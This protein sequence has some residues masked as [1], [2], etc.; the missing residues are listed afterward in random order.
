M[1][2]PLLHPALRSL[3]LACAAGRAQETPAPPPEAAPAAP[4]AAGIEAV[5]ASG[6]DVD[7]VVA[8]LAGARRALDFAPARER[9]A[10]LSSR[11][12]DEALTRRLAAEAA[13]FLAESNL[14]ERLL[15]RVNE[16]AQRG[17][18]LPWPEG[19]GLVVSGADLLGVE[20]A[21]EGVAARKP[22][23]SFPPEL[24]LEF[25]A[26]LP[27]SPAERVELARFAF[28]RGLT[29]RAEAE[30]HA[31]LESDASLKELA[32]QALAL[33][34]REEPP[35]GGYAWHRGS[36]LPALEVNRR[37]LLEDVAQ[38]LERALGEATT[39]RL[40]EV[41]AAPAHA[42]DLF[43][44][45]LEAGT[46][47]V[48]A[49]LAR[50][51]EPP[52]DWIQS[53]R[54]SVSLRRQRLLQIEQWEPAAKAAL[55][56]IGRYDKPDQPKVDEFRRQ[57][58]E[59]ALQYQ[60]LR[61]SD[62]LAFERFPARDAEALLL[63][64][65]RLEPALE[66][67]L[68]Y[69]R[70]HHG[71]AADPF[72]AVSPQG[73]KARLLPGRAGAGLEEFA[74][75]LLL[76]K[77]NRLLDFIQ[78]GEELDRVGGEM[79]PWER[80]VL[81][82][83]L[84]D[85]LD[86]YNARVLTSAD[87][88]EYQN[89]VATNE[90]RRTLLL[91]PFEIDERVVIAAR[92]HSQEMKDLGYFGHD[93][94]T[95][96]LRTPTDRVQFA[97][98][99]G[100]AGENCYAGGGGGRGAFEGWYHSPGHHRGMVGGGPHLGVGA[101]TTHALWTQNFAG[102]DWSWRRHFPTLTVDAEARIAAAIEK[103]SRTKHDTCRDEIEAL[104]ELGR[105]AL[106]AESR[107]LT[108]ARSDAAS[109]RRGFA[110]RLARALAVVAVQEGIP[111]AVDLAVETLLALLEDPAGV[112]RGE[113]NLALEHVTGRSFRFGASLEP[114]QRAAAVKR[115][116]DWWKT[117]REG[118]TPR[119]ETPAS[120][121]QPFDVASPV[122]RGSVKRQ[123]PDAPLKV[124]SPEERL[125][126]ARR[127]GGSR[128]T[129]QAVTAALDWLV[130]HQNRDGSWGGR[131]FENQCRGEKCGGAAAFDFDA[132]LTGLSLLCL[133][134]G[135]STIEIG[136][137]RDAVKK[138]LDFLV[139]RM[140]EHGKFTSTSGWYMYQHALATQALVE[141]YGTSGDPF[142]KQAAQKAVDFLVFA[143][144]REL[145]GW[146][147]EARTD[148]DTSVTGWVVL[149]LMT[150]HDAR[151]KVAGF[152]GAREWI[153]RVTEPAYYRVGYTHALDAAI[154]EPRLTAVGLVCRQA[155]GTPSNHPAITVGKEWCLR[156]LPTAQYIDLYFAYYAT[157][158]LFQIGGEPWKRWN[159][160]MVPALLERIHDPR[161]PKKGCRRGSFDSQ[162][163]FGD[164]GG[165]VY[166]T[167]LSCL[168]LEV[169]Y[170]YEK[171]PDVRS[172]SVTGS[173]A[174]LAK[175]LLDQ[176]GAGTA[177]VARAVAM[178]RIEEE[179]GTAAQAP[180]LMIV[181]EPG[182]LSRRQDAAE[183]LARVATAS[184][185]SDLLGLLDDP[186]PTIQDRL[187][188]ALARGASPASV[189]DLARRLADERGH[190]RLW[191]A[192][193][194]GR[195]GAPEA[196]APLVARSAVEP[197]ANVK[198]EIAGAVRALSNRSALDRILDDAG[199]LATDAARRADLRE[200]LR[201][202]EGHGLPEKLAAA[203]EKQPDVYAACLAPLRE[204]GRTGLV[205]LL[206]AALDLED[207][208]G[209]AL[210][211]QLLV[212]LAGRSMN[213]DA[214][215]EPKLRKEAVA[216]WGAWWKSAR[217]AF[218]AGATPQGS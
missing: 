119:I 113:A 206:I 30:L 59:R 188:Q 40:A 203:R 125:A 79:T 11:T 36:F 168:M 99:G 73:A 199:F 154:Q 184:I 166:G 130:R 25:L 115:W 91:K 117:A 172:L 15:G 155:L 18:P 112:V 52:R 164:Y 69:R 8:S 57:L 176:L 148:A 193:T 54:T 77:S 7:A 213:F 202:L 92:G 145:G 190:V 144:N 94:P 100:G 61:R 150:A 71:E 121:V 26:E 70:E 200:G 78:R 201:V 129:E 116:R 114:A 147:Y 157:L 33:H 23:R 14:F 50:L 212:A 218:Q 74:R 17:Q 183:I 209:R 85:A 1:S 108:A 182:D 72:P 46:Q 128:Q 22:W 186:D 86:L 34:R 178:R 131:A 110:T 187:F 104:L 197:D 173:I 156:Q 4:T 82:D 189:P 27:L 64:L 216:R 132:A 20:L 214:R 192:R 21:R 55:E 44:P 37:R 5:A 2:G 123:S 41:V 162:G 107:A 111:Q 124:F 97:G 158:A 185:L 88:E 49:E 58:A 175:P 141:G 194:L 205:P 217:T 126:L 149:A 98:Y 127:L 160:A 12:Q 105:D 171:F 29:A 81:R 122:A 134:H 181:R 102:T 65:E 66:A 169:Y 3:A 53:Y 35:R 153:E 103:L 19:G 180:L 146:R 140:Q 9:L 76:L 28:W 38:K 51:Y 39:L 13:D 139:S 60:R 47:R 204:L 196:L 42:L 143:Q 83:L 32:D 93:S 31:A 16:Q 75:A 6:D 10:E 109:E 179:F 48:V 136:P 87:P 210:A 195:I 165:R 198:N 62:E 67:T 106:P 63:R 163:I 159:D 137:H 120:E 215:A 68:V 167:A 208:D 24:T 80:I 207:P 133:I 151:L 138:G 211:D 161:D 101:D 90:Y 118:F 89:V 174:E 56:L 45:R 95:E 170:R 43:A 177:P 152:K 191:A 96:K 142:L 135:G 84:H